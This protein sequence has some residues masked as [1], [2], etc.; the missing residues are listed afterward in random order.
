MSNVRG[1]HSW[2]TGAV[3]RSAGRPMIRVRMTQCCRFRV[4]GVA[5][6]TRAARVA[7]R[8]CWSSS[9]GPRLTPVAGCRRRHAGRAVVTKSGCRTVTGSSV[10]KIS[11]LTVCVDLTATSVPFA[12][13]HALAEAVEGRV[14]RPVVAECSRP[15]SISISRTS[16]MSGT[17]SI[18]RTADVSKAKAAIGELAANYGRGV[19]LSCEPAMR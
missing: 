10:R 1:A 5:G 15:S 4:L 17:A 7:S 11:D 14:R 13:A 19:T 12:V 2:S 16:P 18:D 6:D 3:D 9:I 8:R